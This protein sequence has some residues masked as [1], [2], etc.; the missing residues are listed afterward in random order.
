MR[1]IGYFTNRFLWALTA[2]DPYA[3]FQP[4]PAKSEMS[5]KEINDIKDLLQPDFDMDLQVEV[6]NSSVLVKERPYLDQRTLE[7]EIERIK[8]S[9][10]EE[11]V[12]GRHANLPKLSMKLSRMNFDIES[13]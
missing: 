2:S 3:E 5:I 4:P 11:A 1:V 7:L 10:Q 6:V 9:V 8:I 12:M 13:A